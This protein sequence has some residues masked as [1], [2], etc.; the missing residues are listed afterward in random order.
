MIDQLTRLAQ[1]RTPL[2]RAQL[3]SL[4]TDLY[5]SAGHNLDESISG[6][7]SQI[8]QLLLP[9]VPAYE[10]SELSA[11]IAELATAPHDVVLMLARDEVA[12]AEPVLRH[13][14]VLSEADLVALASELSREHLFCLASRQPLGEAVTDVLV[15]RGDSLLS[16]VVTSNVLARLS[17]AGLARLVRDASA[18]AAL[19][20]SLARRCRTSPEADNV[21][22]FRPR[23]DTGAV[24]E[25][26]G[27]AVVLPFAARPEP[28]SG[29][30]SV[31]EA[32]T[33]DQ[34]MLEVAL[35]LA[36]HAGLPAELVTRLI[37]RGDTTL[38]AVLCKAAGVSGDTFRRLV[39]IR[40]ERS[41]RYPPCDVE[42]AEHYERLSVAEAA[43]ALDLFRLRQGAESYPS[44]PA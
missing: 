25:M 29:I 36:E 6:L 18:D 32:V 11:R 13:S 2:G 34:R 16:R 33:A 37:A 14:N 44:R 28:V 31:I 8:V 3:L 20:E 40:A 42:V 12:V 21:V 26:E 15:A 4:I 7:Y 43:R 27:D 39:E 24:R 5:A 41:G 19:G 38:L 10:R 1:D 22:P 23:A 30:A 9:A 17:A 35:L